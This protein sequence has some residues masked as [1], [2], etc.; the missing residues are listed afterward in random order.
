MRSG[1]FGVVKKILNITASNTYDHSGNGSADR[2]V[3]TMQVTANTT[4][5]VSSQFDV[6][7]KLFSKRRC[8]KS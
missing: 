5:N 2:K 7:I 4:A 1:A 8:K 3:I 6:V